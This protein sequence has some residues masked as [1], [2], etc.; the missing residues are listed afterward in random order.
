LKIVDGNSTMEIRLNNLTQQVQ[1][2]LQAQRGTSGPEIVNAVKVNGNHLNSNTQFKFVIDSGASDNMVYSDNGL[3][4]VDKNCT[5]PHVLVAN[6]Q[7]V[8]TKGK[9]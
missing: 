7:K 3:I 5:Y 4:Q 1:A 8:P 6:G 2:L 9:G